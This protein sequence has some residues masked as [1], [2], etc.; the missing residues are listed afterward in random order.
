MQPEIRTEPVIMKA[1]AC[2]SKEYGAI[3]LSLAVCVFIF[4]LRHMSD[5]EVITKVL[6][7]SCFNAPVFLRFLDV[8]RCNAVYS[9]LLYY[10][11]FNAVTLLYHSQSCTLTI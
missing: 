11:L 1:K 6:V 8:F 5:L 7:G 3:F 9:N 4:V 10:I 2:I